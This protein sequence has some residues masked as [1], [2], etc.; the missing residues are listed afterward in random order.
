MPY[1]TDEELIE[2]AQKGDKEAYKKLFNRY[3]GKILNYLHRYMGDYQR[4]EEITI[5]TFLDIYNRDLLF[6]RLVMDCSG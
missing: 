3:S 4:A 1:F 2:K 6:A 5:D